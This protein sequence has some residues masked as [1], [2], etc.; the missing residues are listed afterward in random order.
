MDTWATS[1]F[2]QSASGWYWSRTV[3]TIYQLH[4]LMLKIDFSFNKTKIQNC[5]C[6][7][8]CK[9]WSN[10]TFRDRGTT[11][12][13]TEW[14]NLFESPWQ[15]GAKVPFLKIRRFFSSKILM[16]IKPWLCKKQ[17]L[18]GRSRLKPLSLFIS[19][20]LMLKKAFDNVQIEKWKV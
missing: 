20:I 9:Y 6:L 15:E 16:L 14:S 4:V 2:F 1:N 11:W 5:K 8:L 3:D 18:F 17:R 19:L 10:S 13:E 7:H 12:K